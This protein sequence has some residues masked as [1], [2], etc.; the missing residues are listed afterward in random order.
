MNVKEK[1]EHVLLSD[2]KLTENVG[3]VVTDGVEDAHDEAS[4]EKGGEER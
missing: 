1:M 3:G 4:H 2:P